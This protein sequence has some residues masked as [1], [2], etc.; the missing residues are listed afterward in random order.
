MGYDPELDTSP[1][2]DPDAVSYYLIVISIL[3]WMIKLGMIDRITE[4]LLLSSH[5]ALPR[6][7]HL[8]AT[9][10]DMSHVCQ[11]Y[12]PN[13][14]VIFYTKK[15]IAVSLRNVIGQSSIGMPRRLYP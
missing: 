10:H 11:R 5:V 7:G 14:C 1:E 4:V 2:L 8:D 12:N 9:M 15:Y 13:W 6:E 3:R